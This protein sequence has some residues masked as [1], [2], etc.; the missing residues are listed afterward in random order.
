MQSLSSTS[1]IIYPRLV[2]FTIG[3]DPIA[4]SD[5]HQGYECLLP[6]HTWLTTVKTNHEYV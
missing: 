3:L 6:P 2:A 4:P 1:G 5:F